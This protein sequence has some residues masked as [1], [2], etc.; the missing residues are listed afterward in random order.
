MTE[1]TIPNNR[2]GFTTKKLDN[3]SPAAMRYEVVDADAKGLR[4]RVSP[5]GAKT[6]TWTYRDGNSTRRV[7]LGQYGS[8]DG[9]ISLAKA[10][11]KLLDMKESLRAGNKPHRVAEGAPKT[12]EELFEQHYRKVVL[13]TRKRPDAVRQILDHDIIPVIGKKRLTAI[14][15]TTLVHT[16]DKVIDRGAKAHANKVLNTVKQ[17][18]RWAQVRGYIEVSPAA[19]LE[20][21][22]LGVGSQ[23]RERGLDLDDEGEAQA[24][25]VEIP[26]FW[27][28]LDAAPRMS[29]QISLGLKLLLLT[30]VRSGELRLARWENIDLD[31]GLWKIPAENS[32]TGKPWT[33]PL[34]DTVTALLRQL[35]S[36]ANDSD[37][38]MRGRDR[39]KT[40]D[41]K[42]IGHALR[43]L[44]TL[45]DK[46]GNPL[47]DVPHFTAH[48]LRRTVR[49]HLARLGVAPHV[50]EKCLNHSLSKIGKTYAKHTYIDERREALQ[51]WADTVVLAINPRQN[52]VVLEA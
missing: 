47:L 20:A 12:V 40:I 13:K 15:T 38:V 7:T 22:T 24:K 49:S 11:K 1:R 19:P 4:L 23:I 18:F 43:R 3:L 21:K 51:L 27:S 42:A 50:A 33:V 16:I 5:G 52:V 39:R 28:A 8:N 2:F 9:Q 10:R 35:K 48:D 30:G 45:K 36:E 26:A 37:W 34:S 31:K 17:V 29:K 32:K 25:L 6:F 14:T 41:D 44:F 46:D